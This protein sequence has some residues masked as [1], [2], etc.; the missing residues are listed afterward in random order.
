MFAS[1]RRFFFALLPLP[2][3]PSS[4]VPSLREYNGVCVHT[5]YKEK[6]FFFFKQKTKQKGNEISEQKKIRKLNIRGRA[7]LKRHGSRLGGIDD[8]S[9]KFLVFFDFL[10]CPFIRLFGP[11]GSARNT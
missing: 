8:F 10:L 4:L 5:H 2:R 11:F 6:D 7:T 1:L 3:I 9:Y